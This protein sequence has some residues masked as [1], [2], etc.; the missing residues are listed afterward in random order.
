MSRAGLLF[1]ALIASATAAHA[2][3]RRVAVVV[4]NN[5]GGPG[6]GLL[7]YA[8]R[9]ATRVAQILESLG[10][11]DATELL[12]GRSAAELKATLERVTRNAEGAEAQSVLFFFYSGHADDDALL[13]AGS[14]FSF[15]E[16]RQRLNDAPARV[17]IAFVDAC[18]SGRLTR[19]K[20]GKA[21]PVVDVRF[22]DNRSY[23]GR[24]F[25]TSSAVGEASQEAD[26]VGASFFT[27]YLVSA[28][29]GAADFS[30]DRVVSLEEAYQYVYRN[31]LLRTSE[32]LSGPQH[33]TYDVDVTGRG[34]LVL[35]R[36]SP[37][38]ATLVLQKPSYGTYYVRDAAD[39]T[40]VAEVSK[41]R[42]QVTRLALAPGR[43][44]VTR[45]E[46]DRLLETEMAMEARAEVP[47]DDATMRARPLSSRTT[48]GAAHQTLA[49][50]Y[51]YSSGYLQN[52]GAL[53]G[54]RLGYDYDLGVLQ[55]GLGLEYGYDAYGREDGIAVQ[56]HDTALL[57]SVGHRVPLAAM[58]QAA[59]ALQA[60]PAW[61]SETG[62]TVSGRQ[63]LT[64]AVLAYRAVVGLELELVPMV[65]G[66]Y[67]IGGQ[68]LLKT[69]TGLETRLSFGVQAGVG[70]RF[71]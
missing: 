65:V 49:A 33:P 60:G 35:T 38:Q 52:A 10:G 64:S 57:A 11:V 16:L 69:A 20:G 13:M 9:D 51:T 14:R 5:Q 21:V 70:V 45:A 41:A 37:S 54:V 39:G 24:V 48:K 53:N 28:L 31:T 50:L 55:L 42:G 23:R 8:E 27:H 68:R 32:T 22:D 30:G 7:R 66:V 12:L 34:E 58:F 36:L 62:A 6:K 2:E 59:F 67:G 47:L 56:L 3:P 18:Q 71:D 4:G 17:A 25:V 63:R 29:R 15:A 19:F 61:V 43:Y 46:E 40:L 44:K 1:A 26:E